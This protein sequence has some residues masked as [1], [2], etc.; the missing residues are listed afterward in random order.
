ME[1]YD[2]GKNEWIAMDG[3]PRYRAGCMGFI[4][5]TGDEK[6]F[7]VIGGYGDSRIISGVFPV[8]EYYRN[9][10]VMNLENGGCSGTWRDAGDMWDEGEWFRLGRI[11]VVQDED[12]GVP[13]VFML[14]GIQIFR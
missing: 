4:A 13:D 3:L 1:R 12:R 9:A 11:A 2:V 6:Q 5:G 14:N 8:D 7:W 10:V